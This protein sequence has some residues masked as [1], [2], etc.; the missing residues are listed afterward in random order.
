ML[1]P[2]TQILPGE[3]RQWIDCHPT[4]AN[5]EMQMR[6]GAAPGTARPPDHFALFNGL[7]WAN[8]KCGQVSICRLGPIVVEHDKQ[9]VGTRGPGG[10]DCSGFG[11]MNGF[12]G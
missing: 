3:I 6:P 11:G 2:R 10:L 9:S 12:A 1:Y 7:I 5:L 4:R 8:E